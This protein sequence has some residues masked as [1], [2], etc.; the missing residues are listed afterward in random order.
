MTRRDLKE[1][2]T[3][4]SVILARA[5]ADPALE[6]DGL[7]GR[8]T[9]GDTFT[10]GLERYPSMAR[11]R[12]ARQFCGQYRGSGS[13]RALAACDVNCPS[14]TEFRRTQGVRAGNLISQFRRV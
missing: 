10:D 2:L 13:R 1:K 12:T 4:R 8:G 5:A 11:R 9:L 14:R 7:C 3:N 6:R